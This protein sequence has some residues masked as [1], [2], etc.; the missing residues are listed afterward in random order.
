MD[1]IDYSTSQWA[2]ALLAAICLGMSKAGLGAMA[3]AG[4]LLMANVFPVR[5]STGVILPM[6]IVA[7]VFAVW[8]FH[9]FTV[10][11]IMGKL[12]APTI[13][14]VV[15]GWWIMPE[16]P[17]ELFSKIIAAVII[18]LLGLS[19]AQKLSSRLQVIAGDHP[20]I[21]LPLGM[22][23]GI[24][25]MLANAAG[26][27]VTVYLLACRLPKYE[28]V[29]TAAWF[30]LIVNVLKVPFSA[31]LGLITPTTLAFNAV[32]IPAIVAGLY[33]GKWLLGKI[34]Q[35][36]FEWLLIGLSF[37]GCLRLFFA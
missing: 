7:D 11:R 21:A 18:C 15:I 25:T 10:W 32:L 20:A 19:V 27:V 24:T 31:S 3:V 13:A 17:H 23:A 5:E 36:T 37:L 12:L 4:I 22:L 29:G 30:F 6:L 26:A 28:F 16:I 14:G 8:T 34:N 1:W 35:Q 2:F 9:R 33:F